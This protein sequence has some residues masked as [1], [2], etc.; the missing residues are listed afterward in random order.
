ML[1]EKFENLM[2]KTLV[3][4]AHKM[5]KQ[6]HLSAV[7]KAMVALIPFT[8]IG[9]LF[10]IFPAIPNMLGTDNFVCAFISDNQGL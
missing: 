6:P 1:F 9:S 4:V 7:K 8:I 10:S 5:D 3:P 2:N